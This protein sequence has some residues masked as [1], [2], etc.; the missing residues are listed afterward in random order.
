MVSYYTMGYGIGLEKIMVALEL[1]TLHDGRIDDLIQKIIECIDNRP[2]LYKGR[3][4]DGHHKVIVVPIGEGPVSDLQALQRAI[5]NTILPDS[6]EGWAK[7][8]TDEVD[9]LHGPGVFE[10]ETPF[11]S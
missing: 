9:I 6:L 2:R 7:M 8:W 5:N 3:T 11:E 10:L 1:D 4:L